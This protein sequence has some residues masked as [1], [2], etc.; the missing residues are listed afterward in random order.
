MICIEGVVRRGLKFQNHR[1]G[2]R[3]MTE[4]QKYTLENWARQIL[5]TIISAGR[6]QVVQTRE[7]GLKSTKSAVFF[8]TV[9]SWCFRDPAMSANEK[10]SEELNGLGLSD[11]ALLLASANIGYRS[12]CIGTAFDSCSSSLLIQYKH[13]FRLRYYR[14]LRL[15][16][17]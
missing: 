15:G 9:N 11:I 16:T 7:R 3:R 4:V 5:K 17:P 12:S 6:E 13:V 14:F 8:F 1:L 10:S 2:A